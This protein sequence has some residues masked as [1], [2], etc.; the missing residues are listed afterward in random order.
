MKL[1]TFFSL[2]HGGVVGFLA[3]SL[4]GTSLKGFGMILL[5]IVLHNGYVLALNNERNKN[6]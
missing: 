6:E 2:A 3:G 1:S 4:Y 5:I